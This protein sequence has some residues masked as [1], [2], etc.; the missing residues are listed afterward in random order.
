MEEKSN[1]VEMDFTFSRAYP[2]VVDF[3]KVQQMD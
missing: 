3:R 1:V 2:G